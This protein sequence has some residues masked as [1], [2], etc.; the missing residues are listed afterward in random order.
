MK[1]NKKGQYEY[2]SDNY[3]E[4]IK[5]IIMLIIGAIF[6]WMLLNGNGDKHE[7]IKYLCN[8]TDNVIRLGRR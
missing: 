4:W 8:C 5:I 2:D 1:L 3:L 6:V 7:P